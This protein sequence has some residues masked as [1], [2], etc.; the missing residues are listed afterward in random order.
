MKK[1]IFILSIFVLFIVSYM[2]YQIFDSDTENNIIETV[3][4]E[5]KRDILVTQEPNTG[6]SLVT[7]LNQ[8]LEIQNSINKQQ[9]KI[10]YEEDWCIKSIDLNEEDLAFAEQ[11]LN[12]WK[13]RTGEIWLNQ[14]EIS[15][16]YSENRNA[17]LLEPYKELDKEDL[18]AFA[19]QNNR[20]AMLVALQRSDINWSVQTRIANQ[21]L[22]HGITSMSLIHLINREL[23]YATVKY[24]EEQTVSDEIRQR[25][26]NVLTYLYYGISQYD[27]S[28]LVHYVSLTDDDEFSGRSLLPNNILSPEDFD[29]VRNAV[30]YMTE[31]IEEQ[32]IKENLTPSSEKDL[33]KAALH[34]FESQLAFL[35]LNYPQS[36]ENALRIPVKSTP[37]LEKSKCVNRFM[38]VY[39]SHK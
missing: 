39:G 13:Q 37:S 10:P 30:K 29:K 26:I 1:S 17:E 24:E 7:K 6:G 15:G 9:T 32:Q 33:P 8:N 34:E 31:K 18:L 36:M 11:R 5:D 2:L 28:V 16:T 20:H 35:Y 27:A 25:L 4:T 21:L 38:R 12:E 19:E 14:I 3:T 22:V 23:A